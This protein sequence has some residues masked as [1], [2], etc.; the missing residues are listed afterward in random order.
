MTETTIQHKPIDD[1]TTLI[2]PGSRLDNDNA[3]EMSM[4]IGTA[5]L[6]GY[7]DIRIDMSSL[8]LLSSAGIGSII[9]FVEM[10]REKGGDI[11]IWNPSEKIANVLKILDLHEYLTIKKGQA[12]SV[13]A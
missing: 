5:Q 1:K 11:S 9:G 12:E 8:Q 3:T 13:S 2:M 6:E 10:S 7:F 4:A